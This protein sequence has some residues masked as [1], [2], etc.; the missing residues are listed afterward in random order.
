MKCCKEAGS[1]KNLTRSEKQSIFKIGIISSE[2]L[3]R[4]CLLGTKNGKSSSFPKIEINVSWND[5]NKQVQKNIAKYENLTPIMDFFLICCKY[6][7]LVK[8]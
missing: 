2:M 3:Q 7:G 1:K 6:A 8:I 4:I 5:T